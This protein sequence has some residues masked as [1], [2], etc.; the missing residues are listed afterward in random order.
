MTPAVAITQLTSNSKPEESRPVTSSYDF[1]RTIRM[2]REEWRIQH[3]HEMA[4]IF[5]SAF[6]AFEV[7]A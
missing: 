3:L 4:N 2:T 6:D 7:Q 1:V 5:E